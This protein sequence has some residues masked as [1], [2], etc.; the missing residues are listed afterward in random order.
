ME[1]FA[2]P[3][4][5]AAMWAGIV[6]IVLIGNYFA[7]K[8]R[9]SRDRLLEKLAEH[10]QPLP[11]DAFAD[12]QERNPFTSA[13]TLISVGVALAL[14]FWAMTGG[15]GRFTG[16]AGVPDWLPVLGAFPFLIGVARLV[17]ALA[18][19]RKPEKMRPPE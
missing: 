8:R 15:G 3:S 1:S 11:P 17:G 18:D 5:V 12:R 14:F 16:E 6:C 9:A 13:F 2:V 10:G 4:A 19:R 7:Y